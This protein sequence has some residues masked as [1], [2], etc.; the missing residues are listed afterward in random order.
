M[1]LPTSV[2][3]AEDDLLISLIIERMLQQLGIEIIDTCR[4]E[5]EVVEQALT[6]EP[7]LVLLD[8][9]LQEGNGIEAFAKIRSTSSV[10]IIVMTGSYPEI[11]D[12]PSITNHLIKPFDLNALKES[13]K[14][15]FVEESTAS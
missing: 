3:I 2:L 8:I 7:D 5:S 4:T 13:L 10:P 12:H 14:V 6:S 9:H 15:A 1:K 11:T